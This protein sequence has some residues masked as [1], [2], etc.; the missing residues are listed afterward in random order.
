MNAYPGASYPG[1]HYSNNFGRPTH[2]NFPQP[3]KSKSK[4]VKQV[5]KAAIAGYVAHKAAKKARKGLF[6]PSLF[7]HRRNYYHSSSFGHGFGH[8]GYGHGYGRGFGGSGMGTAA[9]AAVGGKVAKKILGAYVKIQIAKYALKF[10]AEA[11]KI[12]FYHKLGYNLRDEAIDKFIRRYQN[13]GEQRR[14]LLRLRGAALNSTLPF[15]ITAGE[16]CARSC[17]DNDT[18]LCLFT[19]KVHLYQ[20]L[21][22][23]CYDCP[24]NLTDCLRPECIFGAGERRLLTVVNRQLPGP[25][26]EVCHNDRVLVEVLNDLPSAGVTLHWHGLTMDSDQFMDGVGGL[27]Q[28]PI[29]PRET[30]TYSFKANFPGTH[31]WHAQDGL[32]RGEGL[33]GPLIVRKPDEYE[34]NKFFYDHDLTA[35]VL[36]ISDLPSRTSEA[37]FAERF[38]NEDTPPATN[39]LINGR[40]GTKEGSKATLPYARIDVEKDKRYR[41]RVINAASLNCPVRLV[42]PAGHNFTVIATD[43]ANIAAF[44]THSLVVYNGERWDVV[45]TADQTPGRYWLT[46]LGEVECEGRSQ[47]VVVSYKTN[48]PDPLLEVDNNTAAGNSSGGTSSAPNATLSEEDILN[49]IEDTELPTEEP[50]TEDTSVL[51]ANTFAED[52]SSPNVTC[53]DE[54]LSLVYSPLPDYMAEP[55]VED[56]IF[57]GFG[58]QPLYNSHFYSLLYYG[59]EFMPPA[60]RSKTPQVNNLSLRLPAKPLLMDSNPPRRSFCNAAGVRRKNCVGDYCECLHSEEIEHGRVVELVLVNEGLKNET[61]PQPV[62]LHGYRFWVLSQVVYDANSTANGTSADAVDTSTPA[63]SPASDGA[64][65]EP[66]EDALPESPDSDGFTRLKALNLFSRD[67]LKRNFFHPIMK[68]TIMIPP[69]GYAIVRFHAQNN[70]YWLGESQVLLQAAGGQGFV[71]QVGNR[72]QLPRLPKGFPTC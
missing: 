19:F 32:L 13:R 30:F 36:T 53:L 40:A 33:Y 48:V 57:L 17:R 35:H 56:T 21:T 28:C 7:S 34:P 54:M 12:Y 14:R 15:N 72:T 23:A 29:Q 71:L 66:E 50:I 61:L 5:V 62:H 51:R 3:K 52:C 6:S 16:D 69:G 24:R 64:A 65:E 41:I 59:P 49:V 46:V 39:L 38:F 18:R 47:N 31:Y 22:R 20:T 1:S 55:L 43:G 60:K 63:A 10:G 68:D 45:L 37:Q 27:T 67:Q 9:A 44:Y 8:G 11:A 2:G 42:A 4:K 25:A 58:A 26:I 70:G